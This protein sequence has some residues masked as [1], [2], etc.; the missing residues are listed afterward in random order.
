MPQDNPAARLKVILE[1]GFKAPK[2]KQCIVT[3]G[4]LLHVKENDT[5]EIFTRLSKVMELPAKITYQLQMHFPQY[6]E[7]S[8]LWRAPIEAAFINQQLGAKWDSFINHINP[9]CIAHL[10]LIGEILHSKFLLNLPPEDEISKLISEL[11]TI[12][13]DVENSS[14]PINIKLYLTQELM[15]LIKMMREYKIIGLEPIIKQTESIIGHSHRDNS[16]YTFLKDHEIGQR[17]LDNLSAI[18]S[19]LTI[20]LSIPQLPQVV[21]STSQLVQSTFLLLK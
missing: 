6:V 8:D 21:E 14:L 20:Y 7:T 13:T 4:E 9:H 16:F 3:W 15:E 2:D 5:K 19:I 10:G 11:N 1:N 12:L 18:S 17:V